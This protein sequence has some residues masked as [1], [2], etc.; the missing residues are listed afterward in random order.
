MARRHHVDMAFGEPVHNAAETEQQRQIEISRSEFPEEAPSL[1]EDVYLTSQSQFA[2]A[3]RLTCR[4]HRRRDPAAVRTGQP[5]RPI[6]TPA[7]ARDLPSPSCDY[8]GHH[9]PERELTRHMHEQHA[10]M[11]RDHMQKQRAVA[12]T[13]ERLR[14]ARPLQGNFDLYGTEICKVVMPRIEN[15]ETARDRALV[16]SE[17]QAMMDGYMEDAGCKLYLFG[18]GV[19]GLAERASD[20]DIAGLAR[21]AFGREPTCDA[22]PEEVQILEE[23]FGALIDGAARHPWPRA[24]NDH[25]VDVGLKAVLRTR[26]PIVQCCIPDVPFR[27]E[28]DK[29]KARTLQ[30]PAPEDTGKRTLEAIREARGA[31]EVRCSPDPDHPERTLL[32]A[33]YPDELQAVRVKVADPDCSY[34]FPK[35]GA[36]TVPV[37][38]GRQ[39]DLSLRLYGVRNSH[40]LRRYFSNP[41]TPAIRIA[42]VAIK[43]WSRAQGIND[44][45]K[46]M[47][48]SYAVTL[49][50][51][52]FLL[53]EGKVQWVD[54]STVI[55]A[56][57]PPVPEYVRLPVNLTVGEMREVTSLFF[58]FIHFYALVFNWEQEVATISRG[59]REQLIR[60]K[61]TFRNEL[62]WTLDNQVLVNRGNCVRYHLCI[63]D[64]Y[65]A[66]D[67]RP[68]GE[69]GLGTL[70][71]SRKVTHH[72]AT[73]IRYAFLKTHDLMWQDPW[74]DQRSIEALLTT[75]CCGIVS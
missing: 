2:R 21:A 57:C 11:V 45:R 67:E 9:F 59:G 72:S 18:S 36:A 68:G 29:K 54:P 17:V 37:V 53:H 31:E 24:V 44:P 32:L 56:E 7:S 60:G 5:P 28:A 16:V 35:E 27:N 51:L 74:Q 38:Y 41:D 47:L 63:E 65:E 3:Y 6:R 25:L 34:A 48:S 62:G 40:L 15:T 70:N 1:V 33:Q 23:F 49:L 71:V 61:A 52:Y 69:P 46:G 50:Y 55:L 12:A 10:H 8:C 43:L 58:G 4:E 30:W 13:E 22:P 20:V 75:R 14:Q 26:V 73:Q 66:A 39:W 19:S 42:G 64:P